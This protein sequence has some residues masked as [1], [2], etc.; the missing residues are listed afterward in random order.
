MEVTP[1]QP[2]ASRRPSPAAVVL[3]SVVASLVW[4]RWGGIRKG[5]WVDLEVYVGGARAVMRHLPLYSVSVDG[6]PFTYPPF[7]AVLFVPLVLLGELGARWALTA[8]SVGCYVLVVVVCARRLRMSLAIAGMVGFAGLALEPFLR[9][10]LLGQVNLVLLALVIV[11][12]LVVPVRYRGILVG[13]AT[14]IKL[15]PGAFIF[16]FLLKRQWGA[17]GRTAAAFGVT[18]AV[19]AGLA[20]ADSWLFWRGGFINLSRFGPEAIIGGDNQSLNAAFMRLSH[21]LTPPTALVLVLSVGAMMLGLLAARRQVESGN[22]VGA[23]VCLAFGS[24]LA[25]PISWTH[26]WVWA[27]VALLVLAQA[28]RRVAAV[29][30]GAVFVIG[31]MWFAPRGQLVELTHSWWQA[32]LCVSY[33]V[34]GLAYLVFS[35][36]VGRRQPEPR[37]AS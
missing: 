37:S 30:L 23:L 24:L 9:T 1:G 35:L 22:D 13:I 19:G 5:I 17:A 36:A 15:L 29:A 6:L 2:T 27:V 7:A 25:S 3:A 12:C 11:D 18:V 33:V 21:D 8:V 28:G 14:G 20:P 31:P 26:H 32:A 34:L 4:L 16:F 10:I